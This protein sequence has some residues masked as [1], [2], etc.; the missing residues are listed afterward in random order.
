MVGG[1]RLTW[2]SP[3]ASGLRRMRRPRCMWRWLVWCE[4]GAAGSLGPVLGS[5]WPWVRSVRLP[6][7]CWMRR[8][9]RLRRSGSWCLSAC[10][11]WWC[12]GWMV[13]CCT[14]CWRS[15]SICVA[16]RSWPW[17]GG[18]L[19]LLPLFFGRVVWPWWLPRQR[20]RGFFIL[21]LRTLCCVFLVCWV[22]RGN[23]QKGT[24]MAK[25]I[26]DDIPTTRAWQEGRRIY[27]RCGYKTQ[28]HQALRSLCAHWDSDQRARWVG[29]TKKTRVVELVR[30]HEQRITALEEVKQA[31]RWI[32]IPYEAGEVRTKIKT[33][34]GVWD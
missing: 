1:P 17:N 6:I 12:W 11:R 7:T 13:C 21:K 25:P 20:C 24:A 14:W 5:R 3:C 19:V 26:A 10:C 27:V 8:A 33:L 22:R 32:S 28:L 9:A 34:G 16:A 15:V 2:R 29:V 18:K 23:H 31:G 30:A 4:A